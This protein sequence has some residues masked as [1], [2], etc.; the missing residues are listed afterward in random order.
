M[1]KLLPTK[2]KKKWIKEK[3]NSEQNS[4]FNW[5]EQ[6]T[7]TLLTCSHD[8]LNTITL[9]AITTMMIKILFMKRYNFSMEKK[10]KQKRNF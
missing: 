6:M 5:N 10:Q 8:L 1:E 7:D 3:K 4:D 2:R 9:T